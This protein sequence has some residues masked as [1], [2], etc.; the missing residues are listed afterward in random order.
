M[1]WSHNNYSVGLAD[2]ESIENYFKII[3]N[4]CCQVYTSNLKE[5]IGDSNLLGYFYNEMLTILASY[6]YT[7][8]MKK[9]L[10]TLLMW[11]FE[12]MIRELGK[13]VKSAESGR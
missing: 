3:L 12:I 11:G 2:T 10:V 8:N 4:T 5:T 7:T 6:H 1:L 9:P 13:R